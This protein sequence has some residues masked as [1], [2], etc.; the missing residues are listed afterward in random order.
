M[1]PD[2]GTRVPITVPVAGPLSLTCARWRRSVAAVRVRVS[3]MVRVR[4]RVRVRVMVRVRVS[5]RVRVRVRVRVQEFGCH[6]HY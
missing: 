3:V 4:V 6:R 1:G 2:G 5:V